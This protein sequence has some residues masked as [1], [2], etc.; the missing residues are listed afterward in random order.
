MNEPSAALAWLTG[1][2]GPRVACVVDGERVWFAWVPEQA[3]GWRRPVLELVQGVYAVAGRWA[4]R[5]LRRRI[6]TGE[7]EHAVDRAVVQV[8]ARRLSSGLGAAAGPVGRVWIDVG[9]GAGWLRRRSAVRTVATGSAGSDEALVRRA[10]EVG[11]QAGGIAWGRH[12]AVGAV[13]AVDGRIVAAAANRNG[14]HK[15]EHAELRL[16]QGWTE[17]E[18][19]GLPE[20]A[21]LAVSLQC[22][23]M[24]AAVIVGAAEGRVEVLF[25]EVDPGRLAMGTALQAVGW[26]R[27]VPVGGSSGCGG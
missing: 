1:R 9:R 8:A 15:C 6:Y 16:V 2:Y 22:C 26:E 24:C 12:R 7:A 23:R 19:R 5:V 13:L 21:R 18:R 14:V 17:R 11:G 27:C 3:P 20:G 25:A 10:A 4:H